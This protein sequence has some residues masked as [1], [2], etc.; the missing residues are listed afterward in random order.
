MLQAL[1]EIASNGYSH[2]PLT[3]IN[4][5]LNKE[6]IESKR[7][8]EEKLGMEIESFVYPLGKFT[9]KINTMVK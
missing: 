8:I 3:N 5:N 6:I 7:I 9:K 2:I 4:I 1:M